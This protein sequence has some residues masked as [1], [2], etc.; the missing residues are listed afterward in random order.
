MYK[1]IYIFPAIVTILD[2]NDYN[3]SFPD[4]EEIITYGQNIDEAY[5][6][7]E[8]ALKLCLF[9]LYED[10]KKINESSKLND[11]KLDK[12]QTMIL[13]KVN[14]KQIIRKYD[15]RAVKKTLTIPSWLNEEAKK[16]HINFSQVLQEALI[17]YLEI[18]NSDI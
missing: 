2:E 10:N 4:F 12:N 5:L 13:V 3:I 6:M 17:N 11:I 7:A 18:N 8:D 15:N 1:D 16:S 14:L 9:D